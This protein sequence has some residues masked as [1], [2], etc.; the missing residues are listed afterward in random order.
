M[1]SMKR[2][3][4]PLSAGYQE[5]PAAEKAGMV[6]GVFSSVA[7]SYDLMN[8]LM[9]GGVHRLWKDRC[10]SDSCARYNRVFLLTW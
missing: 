4:T 9:S 7:S 5:V 3:H 2:R 6:G 10:F 1:M 8:D